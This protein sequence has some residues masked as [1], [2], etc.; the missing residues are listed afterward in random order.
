MNADMEKKIGTR[1]VVLAARA[2]TW[3]KRMSVIAA[4]HM[5]AV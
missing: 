1:C 5:Q 3:K 4:V 2:G